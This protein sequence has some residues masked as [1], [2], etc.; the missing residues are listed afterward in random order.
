MSG[1]G[2]F[3]VI[4]SGMTVPQPHDLPKVEDI[5]L[6]ND[7][8]VLVSNNENLGMNT[9][10]HGHIGDASSADRK[11]A[12]KLKGWLDYKV[13]DHVGVSFARKHFFDAETTNAIR[14][15]G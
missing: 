2:G 12:A 7:V 10:V 13:G 3:S 4:G 9:L 15:E 11:I 6:G 1:H 8:T 14:K 5:Q